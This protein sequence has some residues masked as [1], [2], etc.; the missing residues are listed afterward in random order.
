MHATAGGQ[1]VIA[2]LGD[3]LISS[4]VLQSFEEEA[5]NKVSSTVEQHKEKFNR[6][7]HSFWNSLA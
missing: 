3:K 2:G 7:Q 4:K 6:V 5:P 1:Q